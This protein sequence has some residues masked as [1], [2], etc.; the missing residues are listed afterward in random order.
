MPVRPPVTK[1]RGEE[2]IRRIGVKRDQ[3]NQVGAVGGGRGEAPL[4]KRV[5]AAFDG[6]KQ[7]FGS[8]GLSLAAEV[9]LVAGFGVGVNRP[10]CG[11]QFGRFSLFAG[12]KM[13]VIFPP[14]AFE[15]QFILGT[16]RI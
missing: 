14:A 15:D 10:D 5:T 9:A 1:A 11:E 4:L 6:A 8:L 13:P 12:T 2:L 3:R 16:D 7:G